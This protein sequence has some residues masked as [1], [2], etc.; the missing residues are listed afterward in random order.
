MSVRSAR[1]QLK[2]IIIYLPLKKSWGSFSLLFLLTGIQYCYA[3]DNGILRLSDAVKTGLSNYQSIKARLNYIK[4]SQAQVQQVKNQY[5]PDIIGSLQDAFGTV[6]GQFGAAA[7]VAGT[8]ASSGPA[9]NTQ[10]WNAAFGSIYLLNV[11]WEFISFGR[12]HAKIDAAVAQ[13]KTDSANF[14]QEQFITSV[15]IAGTYLNLLIF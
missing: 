5:L 1:F 4:A 7:P 15:R 9:Y 6:N 14:V 8:V 12:L 10:S 3:Q 2:E 11:N 13:V